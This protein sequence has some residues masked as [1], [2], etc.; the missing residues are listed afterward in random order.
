MKSDDAVFWKEAIDDEIQFILSNKRWNL[1]DLLA[2]SRPIEYKW[3]FK[4]KMKVDGT[5]D[6]FKPRVLSQLEYARAIGCLMYAMAFTRSDIAFAARKLSR[7]TRNNNFYFDDETADIN[8]GVGDEKNVEESDIDKVRENVNV[9]DDD[10]VGKNS[11]I[12]PK[13]GMKFND[14]N[15]IFEFYKRYAYLVGFP[16]RK[17]NSRKGDDGIVRYVTLTCSQEG[18]RSS[19]TSTSLKPQPTS[20]TGCKARLTAGSEISGLW[21]INTVHLEHNH[22]TSPSKSRLYRCNREVTAHVKRKLECND[23][24]GIPLH[25]SFNSAVVEA[26]GYEKMTCIEK[27]CRNYIVKVRRLRLGEGDAAAIQ[28][29]FSKMQTNCPG[30]YF[31]MDLDEE[32]RLKNIFWAPKGIITDQDRAMQNAIHIVFPTTRHRWCLW[33]IMKKLPEKFG[34]NNCKGAIF[35]A[36]HNVVYDSQSPAVFEDDWGKMLQMFDLHENDWLSGLYK[37]RS[38]W[39]PCFLKTNFWVGMSTTQRSESINALFD[40]CHL[41]EFRGILC[42]HAITVL[43]RN[44]IVKLPDTY[45]LRRWR[46]DVS[47]AYTRVKIN[48][49]GWITNPGQL[50]YDRLC[51]AFAKVA[52]LVADDEERSQQIMEWIECQSTDMSIPRSKPSCGSNFLSQHSVQIGSLSTECEKNETV[53]ILDPKFCKS[54]GAPKKLRRKGPL[55]ARAKKPKAVSKGKKSKTLVQPVMENIGASI[56]PSIEPYLPISLPNSLPNLGDPCQPW[57]HCYGVNLM[58][59]FQMDRN[60]SVHTHLIKYISSVHCCFGIARNGLLL[61][62]FKEVKINIQFGVLLLSALL[63]C[64]LVCCILH[65]TIQLNTALKAYLKKICSGIK[66]LVI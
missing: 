66:L 10:I 13:V 65:W 15:E 14:E 26:G 35:S 27:D 36:I 32:C 58:P 40:G 21:R 42:K 29:Y 18:R 3:I 52:D 56:Q 50:R 6:K 16:I 37:D 17:R 2:G 57:T 53:Q 1:V 28:A 34:N 38:R 55:E 62:V 11:V 31:N 9:L 4:M 43:I 51:L 22:K 64:L 48:Y 47:R 60:L 24:A 54:K 33:H 20:Q 49:D 8:V 45:I 44:D 46:R 23:V 12:V 7:Y 59:T 63:L 39:V 30:F 5:I 61:V 19:T 25:K 41:F